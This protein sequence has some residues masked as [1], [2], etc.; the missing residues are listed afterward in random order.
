MKRLVLFTICLCWVIGGFA[1]EKEVLL[2]DYFSYT[3]KIGSS[4][5]E[6]LRNAII[7]GI[8][9][10]GRLSVVDVDA[11]ANLKIEAERR[12][13]EGAMADETAR[14]AQMKTMG[15]NYLLTAH[16]ANMDA[17]RKTLD[18][19]SV[20]YDGIISFTV[21]VTNIADGSIK[22][23]KQFDYSGLNA[24]TGDS[25]E[26][27]ITATLGYIKTSM[28]KFVNDHFKLEST[29]VTIEQSDK[30]KGAVTV[31]VNCGSAVG[32]QKGQLFDV[33]MEKDVAGK[34]ILTNIGTLKA[35]EVQSE[36]MTL[37]KVTKGGKEILEAN[38][39]GRKLIVISGKQAGGL[40]K[41]MGTVLK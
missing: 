41:T 12:S 25:R 2:V 22:V 40:W 17:V 35:D 4:Y 16:V 5:P 31:Y 3:S 11:E 38:Q 1:Q 36:D 24:K 13:S 21:K 15:A 34:K 27:A 19:G 32:I 29:I 8:A 7:G 6:Q 26:A 23:S 30:K 9:E 14:T 39:E 33:K 37:C 10:T 18:N 20:Y 28:Q